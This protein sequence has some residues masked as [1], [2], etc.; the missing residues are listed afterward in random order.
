MTII[1]HQEKAK[2]INA[3]LDQGKIQCEARLPNGLVQSYTPIDSSG[4]IV[5]SPVV[6]KSAMGHHIVMWGSRTENDYAIEVAVVAPQGEILPQA[7]LGQNING[8]DSSLSADIHNNKITVAW[9][10]QNQAVESLKFAYEGESFRIEEQQ[11]YDFALPIENAQLK[12]AAFSEED[13][14]IFFQTLDDDDKYSWAIKNG[15]T[16][17]IV[18]TAFDIG[19]GSWTLAPDGS[20]VGVT[21]ILNEGF[22]NK[23]CALKLDANQNILHQVIEMPHEIQ[24]AQWPLISADDNQLNLVFSARLEDD[25]YQ[26]CHNQYLLNGK[27]ISPMS[28]FRFLGKES[29]RPIETSELKIISQDAF[30]HVVHEL[31]NHEHLA[32]LGL[33]LQSLSENYGPFNDFVQVD[34]KSDAYTRVIQINKPLNTETS[35][36]IPYATFE[37]DPNNASQSILEFFDYIYTDFS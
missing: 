10:N 27:E 34:Y 1:A 29:H 16:E 24:E 15:D 32:D 23:F 3:W 25:S 18:N 5:T 21:E 9:V 6:T 7:T 26:T 20:F 8:F 11:E 31:N 37:I 22:E 13:A 36:D 2:H 19:M 4:N 33:A 17:T 30:S 14:T 28:D 35:T 12:V